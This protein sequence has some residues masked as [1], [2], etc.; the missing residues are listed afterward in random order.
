MGFQQGLSGLNASS[1]S[2]DVTGNNVANASTVGFKQSRAEFA[3]VYAN[4]LVGAG[5]NSIGLGTKVVDVTQQFTQGGITVTNNPLDVAIN[6][7]GFFRVSNGGDISYSRNGQ[8]QLDKNGYVVTAEGYR[9]QGYQGTS[10]VLTPIV[11]DVR[12]FDPANT[13]DVPAVA[14]GQNVT[15]AFQGIQAVVNLDSREAVPATAVFN[16]ADPTSYN[17]STAIST[18]DSLGN[19]HTYQMYFVKTAAAN[20]WTVYATLTNPAGAVPVFTDLSAAGTVSLGNLVFNTSGILTSAPFA[21]SLTDAEQGYVGAIVTPQAFPVDFSNST[22]FGSNYKVNT[23]NQDGYT[24]GS[25]AGFNVGADGVIVGRYTN[26][27]SQDLAQITLDSFRN[28]QGLQPIGNNQWVETSESGAA[29]NQ[30]PGTDGNHGPLQGAATE[31]S[32]VDLTQE[33]VNMIIAQRVYQAN[34]Q[35]IKTQDSILQTIV[36]LR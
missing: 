6:G 30:T 26:G 32:N 10:G 4:S 27:I 14:T 23:L 20:T 34:A 31:D 18:Y 36:N 19:A 1:R 7:G 3:D 33:L 29:L 5:T 8:F 24:T 25:L 16:F 11:T 12:L 28:P 2:L 9:L 35:T 13:S 21:E 17:R 15:A 22:Q